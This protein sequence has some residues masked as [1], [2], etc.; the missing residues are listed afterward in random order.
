[1]ALS[2]GLSTNILHVDR[3][4]PDMFIHFPW[5]RGGYN[6]EN[7]CFFRASLLHQKNIEAPEGSPFGG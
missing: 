1:M 4:R 2:M 5:D 7:G 6:D 3:F